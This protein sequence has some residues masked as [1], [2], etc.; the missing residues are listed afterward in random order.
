M[1]AVLSP[2]CFHSAAHGEH[3][4]VPEAQTGDWE[5]PAQSHR[6]QIMLMGFGDDDDD[7]VGSVDGEC[8]GWHCLDFCK[9][10]GTVCHSSLVVKLVEVWPGMGKLHGRFNIG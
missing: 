3:F 7:D 8:N 10:F 4:Q 5:K 6:G 1:C 2:W 9:A